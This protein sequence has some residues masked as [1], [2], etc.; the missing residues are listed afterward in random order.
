M[1]DSNGFDSPTLKYGT[2]GWQSS[3]SQKKMEALKKEREAKRIAQ[4]KEPKEVQLHTF[5][6][7]EEIKA[8]DS[9]DLTV[10]LDDKYLNECEKERRRGK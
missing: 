7:W 8:D 6:G 1:N 5:H 4:E 2:R 10:F 3:N 9:I